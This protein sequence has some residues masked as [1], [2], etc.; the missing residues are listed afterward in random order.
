MKNKLKK[1]T[2]WIIMGII[3][4]VVLSSIIDNTNTKLKYSD[5]VTKMELG[6]VKRIELL[7]DGKGAYVTLV[8]ETLPREVNIPNMES[9]MNYATELLKDG[10]IELNEKSQSILV[11]IL[12][13]LS[14][15]G[16]NPNLLYKSPTGF[17]L[18]Y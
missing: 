16:T 8:G 12:N 2:V 10:K 3:F 7:A 5:L 4:V 15:F 1:F 9:F 11:T 14:P 18:K 17:C 6:E 13:L